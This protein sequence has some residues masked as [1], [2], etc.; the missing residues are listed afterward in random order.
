MRTSCLFAGSEASPRGE[1]FGWIGTCT[2]TAVQE[3]P[4]TLARSEPLCGAS[5]CDVERTPMTTAAP[6]PLRVLLIEDN[7]DDYQVTRVLLAAIASRPH[8]L[9]WAPS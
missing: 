7:E 4:G 9:E 1:R 8:D 3:T 5:H 6:A 2:P